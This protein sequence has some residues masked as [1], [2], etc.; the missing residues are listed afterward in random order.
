MAKRKDWSITRYVGLKVN[1]KG[2]PSV[3]TGFI[4]KKGQWG[5]FGSIRRKVK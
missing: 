3:I 2:E 5:G 1:K 4:R